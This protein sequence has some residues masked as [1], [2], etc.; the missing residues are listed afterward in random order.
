LLGIRSTSCKDGSRAAAKVLAMSDEQALCIR[1]ID[2][3]GVMVRRMMGVVG[4]LAAAVSAWMMVT[5]PMPHAWRLLVL[6]P[7]YVGVLG[8]LQAKEKT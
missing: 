2:A 6:L 7:L 4:L 1:N 8:L 5:A 3:Q